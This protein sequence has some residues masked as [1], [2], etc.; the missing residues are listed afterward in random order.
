MRS[1]ARWRNRLII[2]GLVVVASILVAFALDAWWSQRAERQVELGNLRALSSDF[3][4]NVTRLETV[5]AR[6]EEIVGASRRLLAVGD[7]RD[8]QLPA[9]SLA[10]L[11]G[12]LFVS[13]R[14]DPVMGAYEAVV[15]SGGLAQIRDDSL[16]LALA[17]FASLVQGRL[18]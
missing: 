6:E 15:G 7:A 1:R 14:F 18:R 2:E 16:R 9:D 4:Q 10:Q 12:S 3:R 8:A 17:D 11:L 5:I 13:S